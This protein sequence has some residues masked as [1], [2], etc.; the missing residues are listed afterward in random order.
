MWARTN[1]AIGIVDSVQGGSRWS[2]SGFT[3]L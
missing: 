1:T 2:L 3:T